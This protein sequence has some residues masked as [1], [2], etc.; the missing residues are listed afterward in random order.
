MQ[1]TCCFSDRMDARILSHVPNNPGQV[2]I[3]YVCLARYRNKKAH[4]FLLSP[5][6][7]AGSMR[8]MKVSGNLCS[9]K[10]QVLH[11]V[12]SVLPVLFAHYSSCAPPFCFPFF[13]LLFQL[14]QSDRGGWKQVERKCIPQEGSWTVLN[15]VLSKGQPASPLA[16]A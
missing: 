11:V 15:S 3:S 1:K 13:P 4:I 14:L 9:N 16:F 10:D 5:R 8:Q 12:Q 6:F 2:C 7:A